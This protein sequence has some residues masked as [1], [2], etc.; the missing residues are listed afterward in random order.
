MKPCARLAARAKATAGWS[1]RG[2]WP[3]LTSSRLT[4]RWP[5]SPLWSR[6]LTPTTPVSLVP[7]SITLSEAITTALANRPELQQ[8]QTTAEINSVRREPAEVGGARQPT[9]D[10]GGI[11]AVAGDGHW[12][13]R[14]SPDTHLYNRTAEAQLGR[15]LA[16]STR[17]VNQRERLEMQIEAE[18]R[19]T[20]QVMRSAE[21]RLASAAAASSLAEQQAASD[22]NRTIEHRGSDQS[23]PS[24][25]RNIRRISLA[26]PAGQQW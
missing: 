4:L 11:A 26:I 8:L 24:A 10:P 7:P 21:A 1:R 19:D 13:R 5:T 6:A 20:L 3:R 14:Y 2:C 15:A 25:S 16:E 17:I 22:T 12:P 9:L 23:V 18:V